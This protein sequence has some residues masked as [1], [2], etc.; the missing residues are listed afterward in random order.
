MF[1]TS[2]LH[3]HYLWPGGMENI[4]MLWR[5]GRDVIVSQYYAYLIL[6]KG[7][8]N[9]RLVQR[10]RRALYFKDYSDIS[11]NLPA[12]IGYVFGRCPMPS[13]NWAEFVEAW[14]DRKVIH[15]RYEDLRLD[16]VGTLRRIVLE[17]SGCDI[18]Q[19]RASTI[20]EK[21]SF[22]NQSGRLPG[23]EDRTHFMRKG[24]VGD[25]KANFSQDARRRFSEYAGKALIR[26][27]Y[28]PDMAWVS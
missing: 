7:I 3:G 10:T 17:L 21:F 11:H 18:G 9:E 22:A 15:V 8:S 4:V 14:I 23:Q 16:G 20:V 19:K 12:F 24:I 6:Q 2:I 1:R 28:E 13:G 26:L 5:D 27:G 25:W